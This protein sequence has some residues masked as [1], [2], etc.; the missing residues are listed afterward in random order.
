MEA[1]RN[2]S[3]HA[4]PGACVVLRAWRDPAAVAFEVSDDGAGFAAHATPR[5]RGMH[6]MSDRL[7]ALGGQLAISSEPGRGTSVSGSV[8]LAQ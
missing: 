1:L 4:G 3:A 7:G 5:G 2:A 8:P 6:N